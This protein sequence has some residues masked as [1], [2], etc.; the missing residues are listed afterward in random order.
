MNNIGIDSYACY[1]PKIYLPIESLAAER[2]IEVDKLKKGLGI[3]KIALMDLHEDTATMAANALLQL[4]QKEKINPKDVGRIYMSTE[5]AIDAAKP[6]SSYVVEMVETLLEKEFG[7]RNMKHVDVV[8][9]TFACVAGVDVLHN[10]IDWVRC[11]PNKIGIVIASDYAKYPLASPGEY[12]QGAGA[13]CF[14]IKANPSILTIENNF[15]IGFKSEHDFFKPRRKIASN[16]LNNNEDADDK[17]VEIFSDEP[18]YDGHFSNECYKNRIEEA[19]NNFK[20]NVA[21][22]ENIIDTWT[23]LVFH[24]PF[25]FQGRKSI[26][27]LF[28]K[29]FFKNNFIQE[30]LN[31]EEYK[32]ENINEPSKKLLNEVSKTNEFGIFI[33][34]KVK[35]AEQFSSEIGNIYSASIFM[36]LLSC[37]HSITNINQGKIGFFS[38]GS[39]SK[40]K[41]FE[42]SLVNGW[43]SKVNVSLMQNTLQNRTAISFKEYYLLHTKRI[44]KSLLQPNNEF[45]LES[46]AADGDLPGKR[47]YSYKNI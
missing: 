3:H 36:A 47:Q 34:Q 39:G 1:I 33:E 46:V 45:I 26:L 4:F 23:A 35:P 24:L 29:E 15:G 16:L 10:T 43:Q 37:L 13:V 7:T 31:T 30:I 6:T 38:Y 22:K 5:S 28:F 41:V 17:F 18:I 14:S 21:T 44:E 27:N 11:N 20:E 40:S 42:G 25:A 2:N 8:D 32:D 9:F 12:T 19:Y